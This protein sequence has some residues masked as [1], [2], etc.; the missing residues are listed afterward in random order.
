MTKHYRKDPPKKREENP[1][2]LTPTDL[3]ERFSRQGDSES[4]KV[5]NSS[6]DGITDQTK[7]K[8][9]QSP[10]RGTPYSRW[11]KNGRNQGG[12]RAK[13]PEEPDDTSPFQAVRLATEY[14]GGERSEME[15]EYDKP[16]SG[17]V[18]KVLG[19]FEK[20]ELSMEEWISLQGGVVAEEEDEDA[21]RFVILGDGVKKFDI[22]NAI[23][24]E[25]ILV[26]RAAVEDSIIS[27][28]NTTNL[29]DMPPISSKDVEYLKLPKTQPLVGVTVGI[30]G[31]SPE[32][33]KALQEVIEESGGEVEDTLSTDM[34]LIL[35]K[36]APT[37]VLADGVKRFGITRI[38]YGDLV[39][40][41]NG[42]TSVKMLNRKARDANERGRT[43]S[44]GKGK[45]G[46]T[47]SPGGSIIDA[48]ARG[49]SRILA[50]DSQ[51]GNKEGGTDT[52]GRGQ[53]KSPG[54]GNR[55]QD[56][57]SSG[58]E[59]PGEDR[60]Q[61]RAKHKERSRRHHERSKWEPRRGGSRSRYEPQCKRQR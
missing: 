36:K 35:M 42:E 15:Y 17:K 39:K 2:T 21:V 1:K 61:S 54:R 51:G 10:Y 7:R 32:T 50:G 52:T 45:Q 16:L 12:E 9:I 53:S 26:T 58:S 14:E 57:S 22:L 30:F 13:G 41:V 11:Y 47:K 49:R 33:S 34:D 56:K 18:F 27:V 38:G 4:N 3:G 48:F 25:Y 59:R 20:D 5:T 29:D 44:P 28:T 31:C 43:K 46:R 55:D 6:A 23:A 60:R 37:K 40:L 24:R 8:Q 19:A